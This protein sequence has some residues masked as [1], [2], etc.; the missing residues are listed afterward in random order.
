ME[1]LMLLGKSAKTAVAG[2]AKRGYLT[3]ECRTVFVAEDDVL[4]TSV[5]Y[6][7]SSKGDS[8]D[9]DVFWK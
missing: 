4:R 6:V 2:N 3:P 8:R 1:Q 5:S 7:K 9:W